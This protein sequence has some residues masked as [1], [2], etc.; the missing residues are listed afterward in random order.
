M[1]AGPIDAYNVI[2]ER[3]RMGGTVRAMTRETLS[4]IEAGLRRVATGVA[5]G[6][7]RKPCRYA[8]TP[9]HRSDVPPEFRMHMVAE[10]KDRITY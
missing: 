7:G 4:L 5:E 8:Y 6:L 3:A 1:V 9:D 2:P 10:R